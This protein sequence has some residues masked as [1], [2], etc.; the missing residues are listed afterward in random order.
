MTSDARRFMTERKAATRRELLDVAERLF[1]EHGFAATSPAD[2]S[3]VA[4][5]GRTTFYEYF[6]DTEDLL[7]ALVEERLPEVTNDIVGA[8]DRTLP[9]EDQLAELAV[10]MVEF[11]A[12]DHVLGL[13]LHQGLPTLSPPTQRRIAAAHA[14]LSAEFARIYQEGVA[15]GSF[16]EMPT[17]L[18]GLFV[19]DLTMAAAKNLMRLSEPKARIHEVADE[20]VRFLLH[21]LSV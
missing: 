13:Q 16:R 1:G 12:T 2:I 18:A 14:S 20:L 6:T 7:A 3:A 11:A 5:M 17:D 8:I 19:Q 4:H 10:R 21:G 15:S 9:L